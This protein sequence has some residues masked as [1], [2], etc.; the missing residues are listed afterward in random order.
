MHHSYHSEQVSL[1]SVQVTTRY[2]F[3]YATKS[4]NKFPTVEWQ[5]RGRLHA[6]LL[7]LGGMLARKASIV[8]SRL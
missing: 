2:I 3:A 6:H 7:L 8:K 1:I 4:Y 5:G